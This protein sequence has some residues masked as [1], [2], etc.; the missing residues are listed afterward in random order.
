MQRATVMPATRRRKYRIY[1]Y[2]GSWYGECGLCATAVTG[3]S[4]ESA[5]GLLTLHAE[6][7]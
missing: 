4:W 1:K 5:R 3:R 6:V 2:W 7:H